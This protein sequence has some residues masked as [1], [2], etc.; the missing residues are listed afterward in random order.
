MIRFKSTLGCVIIFTAL[1]GMVIGCGASAENQ[2]MSD[3]LTT[4]ENTVN[5][6]SAADESK[7]AELKEKLDS[8]KSK[9]AKMKMEIGSEVTPQTIDKLDNKYK[10]ITKKYTSLANKS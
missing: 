4:Y 7:R 9:W 1:L 3:F 6:F 5:E 2:A 10:E 8:F